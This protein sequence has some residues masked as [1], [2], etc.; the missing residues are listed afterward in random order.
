MPF[1]QSSPEGLSN[2]SH[3][4]GTDPHQ[5][6][7]TS[8]PAVTRQEG[9]G[10]PAW[11][12]TGQEM[13]L[14]GFPSVRSGVHGLVGQPWLPLA[15]AAEHGRMRVDLHL[16]AGQAWGLPHVPERGSNS[17]NRTRHFDRNRDSLH[18]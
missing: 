12:L 4:E 10:V 13:G 2:I 11:A 3:C 14:G 1:L 7:P 9:L 16:C 18:L 8:L 17:P 15:T 5:S 6:P